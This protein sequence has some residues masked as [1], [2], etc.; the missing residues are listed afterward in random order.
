MNIGDDITIDGKPTIYRLLSISYISARMVEVVAERSGIR[1]CF[2]RSI[3]SFK[4][5][6]D[7]SLINQNN[8]IP[9]VDGLS[10]E[11]LALWFN[12]E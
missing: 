8:D 6:M 5:S 4:R 12:D 7:S 2:R 11:Q 3:G 1:Y 10:H 9:S